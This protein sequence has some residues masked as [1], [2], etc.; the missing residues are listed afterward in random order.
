M[1]GWRCR[2]GDGSVRRA[3]FPEPT[4]PGLNHLVVTGTVLGEPRQ[5]RSPHGDLVALLL[6]L[7]EHDGDR[8]PMD[9]RCARAG[10]KSQGEPGA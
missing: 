8:G 1:N 5:T 7:D 9:V 2:P 10:H 3:P 4:P 6:A